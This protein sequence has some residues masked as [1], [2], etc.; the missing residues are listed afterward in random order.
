MELAGRASLDGPTQV[1]TQL[2]HFAVQLIPLG[3]QTAQV[4]LSWAQRRR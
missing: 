1:R 2:T 3:F 4:V